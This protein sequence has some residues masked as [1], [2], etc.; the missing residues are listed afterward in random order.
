M[1]RITPQPCEKL[2]KVFEKAG[3]RF[4]RQ[5]GSHVVMWKDG[6]KR[7]IVIPC[8]KGRDVDEGIISHLI[9]TAGMTREQYFKLLKKV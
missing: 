6:C 5:T 2:V 7:P 1:A 8:H 3:A 9:K 4:E